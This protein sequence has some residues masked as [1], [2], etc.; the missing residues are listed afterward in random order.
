[1][2]QGFHTPMKPISVHFIL[3]DRMKTSYSFLCSNARAY[4]A[5]CFL[6]SW[7]T[8]RDRYVVAATIS[9][10]SHYTGVSLES[11]QAEKTVEKDQKKLPAFDLQEKAKTAIAVLVTPKHGRSFIFGWATDSD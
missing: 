10:C 8:C 9:R 3:I 5:V 4:K 11:C 1:M 2:Q 7:K 6:P